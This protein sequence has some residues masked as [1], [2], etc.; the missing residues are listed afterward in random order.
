MLRYLSHLTTSTGIIKIRCCRVCIVWL[1]SC[2]F[3]LWTSWF[4]LRQT[5][6]LWTSCSPI[7]GRIIYNGR[8]KK[9]LF[10]QSFW[11]IEKSL[12]HTFSATYMA[13]QQ[14][15]SQKGN[16]NLEYILF[17]YHPK[18]Y[19]VHQTNVAGCSSV[20]PLAVAEVRLVL[21]LPLVVETLP[22]VIVYTNCHIV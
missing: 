1:T 13:P 14:H 10:S 15:S 5:F 6:I 16:N 21:L 7:G 4:S 22:F 20:L 9:M 3:I 12:L 2:T 17:A 18:T 11:S 8:E 19:Q